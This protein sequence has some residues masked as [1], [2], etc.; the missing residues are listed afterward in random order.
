MKNH[1]VDPFSKATAALYAKFRRTDNRFRG[2][3][4]I[5]LAIIALQMRYACS[6]CVR[7]S[8]FIAR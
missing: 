1:S 4:K 6:H 3:I 7:F 5:Q 8:S 2:D